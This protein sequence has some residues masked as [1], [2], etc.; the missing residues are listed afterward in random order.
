MNYTN[1]IYN[2]FVKD[3]TKAG[4]NVE[5]YCGRNFYNGPAVIVEAD[6]FQDVC[7]A[8]KVRLQSDS[9]GKTGLVVYPR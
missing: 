9:M 8:T 7:A 3:M 4:F 1:E 6:E 2:K 5:D